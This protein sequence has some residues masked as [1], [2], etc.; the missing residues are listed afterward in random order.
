MIPQIIRE[1]RHSLIGVSI[2]VALAACGG[3][4]GAA[5]GGGSEGSSTDNSAAEAAALV[6]EAKSALEALITT[7]ADEVEQNPDM[8]IPYEDFLSVATTFHSA[9]ALDPSNNEAA[10]YG[11]VANLL[12]FLDSDTTDAFLARLGWPP[13]DLSG[14]LD[15]I[16]AAY[17]ASL[18]PPTDEEC[19]EDPT[20]P[21]CA[22]TGYFG[23]PAGPNDDLLEIGGTSADVSVEALL[24]YV[25][26]ALPDALRYSITLLDGIDSS[27]ASTLSLTLP[28]SESPAM[29]ILAALS[30]SAQLVEIDYSDAKLLQTVLAAARTALIAPRI[31]T[32]PGVDTFLDTNPIWDTEL[33]EVSIDQTALEA[34]FRN[35][36][37]T[38][39]DTGDE[40][41]LGS[42]AGTAALKAS[43]DMALKAAG[44]FMTAIVGET[45]DQ[46][47]DLLPQSL[48]LDGLAE[49]PASFDNKQDVV[50]FFLQ[51]MLQTINELRASVTTGS[52]SI[53]A[54]QTAAYIRDWNTCG[55]PVSGD[56]E[57]MTPHNIVPS[58][59]PESTL[60]DI[61]VI[62]LFRGAPLSS[63]FSGTGASPISSDSLTIYDGAYYISFLVSEAVNISI[64]TRGDADTSL[65]LGYLDGD[66]VTIVPWDSDEDSG[67]GANA[68]I[69]I[70]AD[71]F[72]GLDLPSLGKSSLVLYVRIDDANDDGFDLYVRTA[73][74]DGSDN[75]PIFLKGGGG[76]SFDVTV[77]RWA[78]LNA[79]V[80]GLIDVLGNVG[81][82][83]IRSSF[84][85]GDDS[86]PQNEIPP[87][88]E[89][90]NSDLRNFVKLIF[91][92]VAE[93]E[94]WFEQDGNPLNN[95]E[96]ITDV[97][98][99]ELE[100]LPLP[101]GFDMPD[102][103]EVANE[104][105]SGASSFC[106]YPYELSPAFSFEGGFS[107]IGL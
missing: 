71:Y 6:A 5:G 102:D 34:Y 24:A 83:L 38:T 106:A 99:L 14:T 86:D 23:L 87:K 107:L 93:D 4:G 96:G 8:V 101:P 76:R 7:T 52:A 47:D 80:G 28:P 9:A 91:P 42:A 59:L 21:G 43:I 77:Y 105:F 56:T 95:A 84:T 74:D 37:D 44:Q 65:Q 11:A 100:S 94:T 72:N 58:G 48:L 19:S 85:L 10:F 15:D 89:F 55:P 40:P 30:G 79:S 16:V 63:S 104:G 41:L 51:P 31:A 54:Y 67:E 66:G 92:Q 18:D 50:L 1:L 25:T 60:Q 45:D 49:S 22:I 17:T 13:L 3:G 103:P 78:T 26:V 82:K 64:Y 33:E 68:G 90:N 29:R 57:D 75:V 98:N 36:L 27:F 62:S 81:T 20:L 35:G 2:A 12:I 61:P 69:S 97:V 70:D 53:S 88:V 32:Y 73:T 46:S 39:P